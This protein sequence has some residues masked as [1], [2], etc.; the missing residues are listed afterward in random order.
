MR[1]QKFGVALRGS[2]L[3]VYKKCGV[4]SRA[5]VLTFRFM[6]SAFAKRKTI[7]LCISFFAACV[8]CVIV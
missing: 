3:C 2:V 1:I 7:F 5:N 6:K 8:V 4:A